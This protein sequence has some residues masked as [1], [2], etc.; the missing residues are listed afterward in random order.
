MSNINAKTYEACPTTTVAFLGLGVMGYPMAGHLASA[1]HQVR[2]YN[3]TATKSIA[4]CAEFPG[5]NATK[6]FNSP[7]PAARAGGP[8]GRLGVLLRG[9]RRRPAQCLFGRRWR[10]CR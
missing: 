3:R 4:W 9:Q 2:V 7:R 1:G 5:A 10:F 6:G 8:G